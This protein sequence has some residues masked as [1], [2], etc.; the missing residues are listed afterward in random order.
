[1]QQQRSPFEIFYQ[2][3]PLKAANFYLKNTSLPWFTKMV[4]TYGLT[5][6]TK[7]YLLIHVV[8]FILIGPKRNP[9]VRLC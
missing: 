2:G 7:F 4:I 9:G 5:Q 8:T 6:V 3:R 1:M